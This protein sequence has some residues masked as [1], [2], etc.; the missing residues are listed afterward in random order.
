MDVH[1]IARE[2]I[3]RANDTGKLPDLYG[4]G[5]CNLVARHGL[6]GHCTFDYAAPR[7]CGKF[8]PKDTG[9]AWLPEPG[10]WT[11]QRLNA[12]ALLACTTPEDFEDDSI[13]EVELLVDAGMAHKQA[14]LAVQARIESPRCY[15]PWDP[16]SGSAGT[17]LLHAFTWRD[18]NAARGSSNDLGWSATHDELL[19]AE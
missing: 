11:E 12:I 6:P 5:I 3:A 10:V 4:Y 1:D 14:V 7:E 2:I 8:L 17:W 15:G 18:H 13:T 19:E 9:S 16:D